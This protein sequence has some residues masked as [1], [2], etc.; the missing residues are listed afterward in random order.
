MTAVVEEIVAQAHVGTDC[1][2]DARSPTLF[3]I[4]GFTLFSLL[5]TLLGE[6]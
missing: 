5:A 4:G 6:R 2:T 3:L 1:G